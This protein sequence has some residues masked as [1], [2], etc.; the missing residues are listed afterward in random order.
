MEI[1]AKLPLK[2]ERIDLTAIILFIAIKLENNMNKLR[3]PPWRHL[4]L[5]LVDT[6]NIGERRGL[7]RIVT[8]Q[9]LFASNLLSLQ[10]L[11]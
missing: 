3:I 7:A 10:F 6:L 5:K 2:P 9:C 1:I 8:A 11:I 4:D